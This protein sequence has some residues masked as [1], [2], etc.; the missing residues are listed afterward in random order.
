MSSSCIDT[1][2]IPEGEGRACLPE[3]LVASSN[4]GFSIGREEVLLA[5]R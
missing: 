4:K 5:R 2:S 1:K 3:L